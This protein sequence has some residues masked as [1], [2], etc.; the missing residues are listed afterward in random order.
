MARHS[1][2]ENGIRVGRIS[3][4]RLCCVFQRARSMQERGQ[5]GMNASCICFCVYS[6]Y[7]G[8]PPFVRMLDIKLSLEQM[9]DKLKAMRKPKRGP[10]PFLTKMLKKHGILE[11]EK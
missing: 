8:F 3:A 1:K 5:I 10:E 4:S 11:K 9:D 7:H 6:A 2:T